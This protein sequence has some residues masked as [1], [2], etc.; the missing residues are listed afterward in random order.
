MFVDTQDLTI[1]FIWK[2][3][4]AH[5]DP[6]VMRSDQVG[7]QIGLP[8]ILDQRCPVPDQCEGRCE[9]VAEVPT[10]GLVATSATAGRLR[11]QNFARRAGLAVFVGGGC[12]SEHLLEG[13]VGLAQ[14]VEAGCNDRRLD[15]I[16]RDTGGRKSR[17]HG[18]VERHAE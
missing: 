8:I 13:R 11:Q 2:R 18:G 12:G 10:P 16:G 14:V 3:A 6:T 15:L 17:K 4:D 5:A 9:F 7:D 1:G